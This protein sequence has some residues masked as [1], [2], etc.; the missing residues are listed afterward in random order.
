ML[1]SGYLIYILP[2]Y[3]L[4]GSMA[5]SLALLWGRGGVLS[6]GQAGF[7]TIGAYTMGLAYIWVPLVN[8]A[9]AGMVVSLIVGGLLAAVLGY[10]LFSVGVRSAYFV[11]V[12]LAVSIIVRQVAVSQ[13]QI[14][15]GWNGMYID[16][17]SL[18]LGD[19]ISFSLFDDAPM[20]YFV[21]AVVT[22][23]YLVLRWLVGAKFGK[24]L[25]GIRE[26]EDRV[27]SLGFNVSH[28][29]TAAFAIAG[30]ISAFAGALYGTN[31]GFVAP[32][33][34]DVN[35]STEVV[36][37]VAIGG[38]S[39]LLSAFLAAIAVSLLSNYLSA[40]IPAYWPLILGTLFVAVIIF[41][42]G[43]VAGAISR[44]NQGRVA[45]SAAN[46]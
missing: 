26:N 5:M 6:F 45:R 46:G 2:Q 7:Y 35:F 39:S 23:V 13:S 43:G 30:A 34:A 16:R 15:G 37:W 36:V 3:M 20:Y 18:T 33:L 38:R 1:L 27:L 9:Y 28:Y 29:K 11:I 22:A 44:W 25:V 31:A 12:T 14:T 42:R 10:F 19:R 24:V 8:P 4:H 40:L 32:A 41:F 21:L 17:M